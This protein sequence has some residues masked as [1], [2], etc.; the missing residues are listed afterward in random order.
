MT[1]NTPDD[2]LSDEVIARIREAEAFL[3]AEMKKLGLLQEDG[4]SIAQSTR[5]VMGATEVVLRPMHLRKP[6]PE[7]LECVVRVHEVK[8]KVETECSPPDKT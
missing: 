4:W 7:G 3:R 5:D 6:A 2:Q 8:P 1:R